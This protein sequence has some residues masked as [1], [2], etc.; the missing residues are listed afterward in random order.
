MIETVIFLNTKKKLTGYLTGSLVGKNWIL[1][2]FKL[3]LLK[4]KVLI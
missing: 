4:N 3:H 2:Q 1:I